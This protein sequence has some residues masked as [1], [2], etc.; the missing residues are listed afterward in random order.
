LAAWQREPPRSQQRVRHWSALL[1][2]TGFTVATIVLLIYDHFSQV[3]T[4]VFVPTI[5][6]L[7]AG[8]ARMA[9]AF[10]DILS[11]ADARHQAMTDEL[12]ELPNRRL[13]MKRL[14]DA[15]TAAQLSD[16]GL[17]TLLLDLDNFKSLNDTLGH[18]AGDE[19]LRM[20]GPR[21][22]QAVR[23][24]DT[25]ARLGGDEFAI[26]L[27]PEPD[28]IGVNLVA[29]KL[30]SALRA[31]FNVGGLSFRLNASIGIASFPEH[32][33]SPEG[34]LKCADVAMYLAKES[35]DG[36]ERYAPERDINSTERL[37]LASDLASALEYGEIQAYYQPIADAQSRQIVGAEALVRWIRPDGTVVAP[38][39]FVPAACRAGLARALTTRVLDLA[40]AQLHAWHAAGHQVYVSINTTVADLLDIDN[41]PDQVAAALTARH[42]PP[43]AL[44]LEVTETAIL[45]DPARIAAAL[46]RLRE[47]GIGVA[48]DDFGT[49]YSS[50]AHLR[51]LPLGEVKID[52]SFVMG[53]SKGPADEA[54]VSATIELAHKLGHDVV[55]EGVEDDHTWDT[56]IALGC[57]RIQ[58]YALARPVPPAGFWSQLTDR[59]TDVGAGSLAA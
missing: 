30:L 33:D 26:L 32:A 20:I 34:L 2:P 24:T 36:W 59:H 25:I 46:T 3:P 14:R 50:L 56:L 17:T 44:V 48:L 40:I 47:L 52:R 10:R 5:I 1:L 16:R 55:A 27:D 7:L 54:I 37:T 15:I 29:E 57:D 13:F 28:A 38:D 41:F 31:P 43:Q 21:L 11:L 53:M 12:T 39:Q 8:S 23:S 42:L 58:G 35:Q 6:T 18:D 51:T 9:L 19:L 45:S 49:G 22:Q 4:L